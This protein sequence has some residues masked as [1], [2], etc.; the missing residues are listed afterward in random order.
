MLQTLFP[1]AHRRFLALPL[2]GAIAEGFD[3]S[4]VASG[5]TE[6]SRRDAMRIL[7]RADAVLR[8]H[9]PARLADLPHSAFDHCWRE[10]KK[11][12]P[13]GAGTI[14]SVERYLT[15]TGVLSV[16]PQAPLDYQATALSVE[17]AAHL[18]EVH[19][20]AES[21]ASYHEYAAGCFL[22]HLNESRIPLGSLRSKDIDEYV[23]LAGKRLSRASLQH[24]VAVV[25]GLLRYC[26]NDG[27]APAGL[28]RQIDSPRLYQLEK[29]PRALAWETVKEILSSI[30]TKSAMGR[31]DYAI[32]LMVATYG[33]RA[34]EVVAITLDDL[35]WRQGSLRIHQRKTSS[36]LELPLTNEVADAVVKHLKRTPPPH[37]HRRLF[38]RM[39]AP[40]GVLQPSAVAEVFQSAVR[41]SGLNVPLT[42]AHC[43]RHSLAVHLL[44]TG[45]PLKTIG[46]ILGHRTAQSTSTYLRLATG[47]LR[48]V[49]LP[50]PSMRTMK[51]GR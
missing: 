16:G 25:R 47:D 26:A 37:P 35:R 12:R 7:K 34:S 30:D 11:T 10:L 22:R 33:L 8:R 14:R 45:T 27:K 17:Y 44:K 46:D 43:L 6:D 36:P 41:Q 39:R 13:C 4:L 1:R 19:G 51:G 40:M 21:T 23:S 2:L 24:E 9:G 50:V 32:L 28:D 48:Q 15:S 18:R 49:S 29:L 31:R 42:G 5:Y 3:D 38:L 20:F